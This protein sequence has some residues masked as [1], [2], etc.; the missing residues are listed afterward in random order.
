MRLP[1]ARLDQVLDRFHEVEARMAAAA[2][3]AEV[4]RLAKEHAELRPVATTV[5]IWG[6]ADMGRMEGFGRK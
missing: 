4:V 1:H 2:D 3:G 6:L 5:A